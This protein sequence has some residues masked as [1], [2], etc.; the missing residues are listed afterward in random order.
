[1]GSRYGRNQKRKHREQIA[2]QAKTLADAG[3]QIDDQER[4]LGQLDYEMT[5][6]DERIRELLGNYSAFRR[7]IEPKLCRE[8]ERTFRVNEQ[9]TLEE[10]MSLGPIE[11]SASIDSVM[12]PNPINLIHFLM[13]IEDDIPPYMKRII[14]LRLQSQFDRDVYRYAVSEEQLYINATDNRYF[15]ELARHIARDLR[16]LIDRTGTKWSPKRK[17]PNVAAVR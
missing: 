8:I 17:K 13:S 4:R 12:M 15:D 7:H 14:T 5:M 2:A 10:L 9:K 6:W 3:R 1:M 16:S 11:A